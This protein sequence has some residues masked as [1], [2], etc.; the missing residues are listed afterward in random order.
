MS[1][2]DFKY[3]EVVGIANTIRE[4]TR[5]HFVLSYIDILIEASK[6]NNHIKMIGVIERL[7]EW[8]VVVFE[9]MENDKYLYNKQQHVKGFQLLNYALIEL[10]SITS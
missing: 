6:N 10:Q 1:L 5:N 4:Y 3:Y 7:I 8:Y 2:E 9:K